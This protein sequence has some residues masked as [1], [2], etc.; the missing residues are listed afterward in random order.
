MHFDNIKIYEKKK[1]PTKTYFVGWKGCSSPQ[2]MQTKTPFPFETVRDSHNSQYPANFPDR[3]IEDL[4]HARQARLLARV[5]M[6][7]VFEY[8]F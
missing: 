4:D 5:I 8:F 1:K 3:S 2:L 6:A 7:H